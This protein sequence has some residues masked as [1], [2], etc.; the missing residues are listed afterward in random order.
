MQFTR[1]MGQELRGT[2]QGEAISIYA[3]T[4]R[5]VAMSSKPSSLQISK[6][7][8]VHAD[9]SPYLS[10]LLD[11]TPIVATG[12]LGSVVYTSNKNT[13]RHSLLAKTSHWI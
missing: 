7:H 8:T 12:K 6:P 10:S 1:R 3:R 4:Y 2:L 5:L 11:I 13:E 9:Q